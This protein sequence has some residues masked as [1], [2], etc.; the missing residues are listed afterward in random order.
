MFATQR[1]VM[2]KE[3]MSK[4]Y[5]LKL[6]TEDRRFGNSVMDEPLELL[7]KRVISF[8]QGGNNSHRSYNR[9]N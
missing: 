9:A 6:F 7:L 4:Y 2:I 8:R 5:M 3:S 1:L